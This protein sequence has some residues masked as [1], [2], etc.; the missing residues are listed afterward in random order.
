VLLERVRRLEGDIGKIENRLKRR[1]N[2]ED[3]DDDDVTFV[4]EQRRI[5][6]KICDKI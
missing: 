2:D 4:M 3:D 5:H 1:R 6:K